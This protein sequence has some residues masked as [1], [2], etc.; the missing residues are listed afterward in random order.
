MR[1]N[2]RNSDFDYSDVKKIIFRESDR[3]DFIERGSENYQPL[4]YYKKK[5]R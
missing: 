2:I 4:A 5:T 3:K 1:T